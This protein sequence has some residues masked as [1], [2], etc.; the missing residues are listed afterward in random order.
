[1]IMKTNWTIFFIG[2]HTSILGIGLLSIFLAN[3][4]TP[5]P[6]EVSLIAWVS[7]IGF[8]ILAEIKQIRYKME[9]SNDSCS[10]SR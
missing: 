6:P 8:F 10:H 7:I 9:A 2:Y 1:M 4:I 3:T 5:S